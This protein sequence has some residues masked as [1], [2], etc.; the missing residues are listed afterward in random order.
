MG[1]QT[2]QALKA[3]RRFVRAIRRSGITLD[4]AYLF[5]SY[6]NGEPN[7]YSDIDVALVSKDL[8]GDTQ[9]LEKISTAGRHDSRI[10]SVRFHPRA[11]RDENPLVWEIKQTGISLVPAAKISKEKPAQRFNANIVVRYWLNAAREDWKW[12]LSCYRDTYKH[13]SYALHFGRLYIEK[14]LKAVVVKETR[15]HAPFRLSLVELAQRTQLELD[16]EQINLL[17]RLDE[18]TIDNI[19]NPENQ[20][21]REK[22][23]RK[24]SQKELHAIRKLGRFLEIRVK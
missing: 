13:H 11:F 24:F 2:N 16:A 20:A 21:L 18:Y 22:L 7:E 6:V 5:G 10:E 14:L 4:A 3:A 23:T 9:D 1:S 15:A 8:T 12:A 17:T 19:D